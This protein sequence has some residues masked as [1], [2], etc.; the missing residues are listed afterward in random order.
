MS[1]SEFLRICKDPKFWK[2]IRSYSQIPYPRIQDKDKFLSDVYKTIVNRTYYP[3]PPHA[4]VT[5]NKGR[6]V[7]RVVPAFT[8]EDLCVYYYCTRKLEKYIA[9]NRI[10]GTY[11]GFGISGRLKRIEEEEVDGLRDGLEITEL[12]DVHYVFEEMNG[13]LTLTSLNPQ[14]WFEDWNDFTKKLYLNC[15][16]YRDGYVAELDISNFYD[17]IQ[18]DNLEYKLR[19]YVPQGCNDVVYLVCHFLRFWNRH[20]NFYRQQGAGIPQDTFGECSRILAN[21]Y[22]QTYDQK[23]SRYCQNKGATFFRYADDQ[24]VFANSKE[25]LEE[26]ITKAS[27]FLMREGLNFNQKK[28]KIMSIPELRKYYSFNSFFK[29]AFK[30]T[31]S[32]D[33]QI[34]EQQINF[35][36]KNKGKLK[37]GGVSLLR[38]LLTLLGKTRRRPKNFTE[39]KYHILNDFV[40]NNYTLSRSDLEKIYNI[41]TKREQTQFVNILNSMIPSC[42]CTSFLYDLRFFYKRHRIPVRDVGTRVTFLTRFYGF[43]R[44]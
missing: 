17:S 24:I 31:E 11:G 39:L 4:Y 29:L 3:R 26:I 25:D 28:V 34:L 38:R 22:L 10:P 15:S 14:A 6:G 32:I 19:K 7:L 5:F 16:S 41:L 42:W 20:I 35:Y 13:Y 44:T 21:F 27:T 2:W 43:I 40:K 18:L 8:L 12:E 23:I 33:V 36:L 37:K 9:I 1:K 30:K